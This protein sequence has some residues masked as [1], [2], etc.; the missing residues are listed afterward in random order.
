MALPAGWTGGMALE[1]STWL[2]T[3][4]GGGRRL[5]SLVFGL[6]QLIL[7]KLVGGFM[8]ALAFQG[9][10]VG[11]GLLGDGQA[12]AA[13]LGGDRL[14]PHAAVLG[15]H[16]DDAF[17]DLDPAFEIGFP[18]DP[19]AFLIG[20]QV[21]LVGPDLAGRQSN[22]QNQPGPKREFFHDRLLSA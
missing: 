4:I 9:D 22:Q 10:G 16:L 1:A 17:L 14:G 8:P 2:W 18:F 13:V 20:I 19:A 7:G 15:Q 6:L 11:R 5:L 21:Q 12:E 3:A